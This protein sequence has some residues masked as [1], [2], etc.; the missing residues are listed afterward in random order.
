MNRKR[1]SDRNP[2]HSR[3]SQ[4]LPSTHNMVNRSTNPNNSATTISPPKTE[5]PH[6]PYQISSHQQHLLPTIPSF[7]SSYIYRRH[8]NNN[9]IHIHTTTPSATHFLRGIRPHTSP[10]PINPLR[11]KI[12]KRVSFRRLLCSAA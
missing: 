10:S 5:L 8:N 11:R 9:Y 7:S 3:Q 2:L 4:H 1:C 12:R 6:N